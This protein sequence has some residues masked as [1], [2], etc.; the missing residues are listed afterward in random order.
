MTENPECQENPE[1][2]NIMESPN[3]P[4]CL[5]NRKSPGSCF[6][7]RGKRL[8][9]VKDGEKQKLAKPAADRIEGRAH[10]CA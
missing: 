10:V 3:N 9:G 1:C 5:E 7:R 8:D 2:P 6:F 4:E